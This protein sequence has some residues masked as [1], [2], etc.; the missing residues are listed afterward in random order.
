MWDHRDEVT[1]LGA[2]RH[3]RDQ[4]NIVQMQFL[5]STHVVDMVLT[6]SATA[7]TLQ[8]PYGSAGGSV[9]WNWWVMEEENMQISRVE[10]LPESELVAIALEQTSS[11]TR[12]KQS[13][14]VLVDATTGSCRMRLSPFSGC[15]IAMATLPSRCR[16]ARSG[17]LSLLYALTSRGEMVCFQENENGDDDKDGEAN[18]VSRN[19]TETSTVPAL[20]LVATTNTQ[21]SGRKRSMAV[22]QI[23][24]LQVTAPNKRDLITLSHSFCPQTGVGGVGPSELPLLR[25]AF[26]RSFVARHLQRPQ[27]E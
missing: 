13:R 23:D 20:P 3:D 27:G 14:I 6:Q 18:I 9:G 19:T 7:V 10:Y 22:L 25:G 2:L 5:N 8:S 1:L 4:E 24:D 16:S 17:A 26:S 12:D 15:V 21:T 11:A